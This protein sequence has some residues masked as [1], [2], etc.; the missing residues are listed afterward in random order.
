MI[1]EAVF[2]KMN[3]DLS[4]YLFSQ[5]EESFVH[6]TLSQEMSRFQFVKTG[7]IDGLKRFLKWHDKNA[8]LPTLSDDPVQSERYLFVSLI[9]TCCRVCIE[10]GMPSDESYGLS[11]LYIRRVDKVKT[12]EEVNV[13]AETMLFDYCLRMKE[14]LG[15][16]REYS[17]KI[18]ACIN[19]ISNHLHDRITVKELADELEMNVSWLSVSFAS[20]VGIPVS[21]YI[22]DQKL[23]AAKYLL[24]YNDYSCTD[25]AEYLGFS[26]ASHFSAAFLKYEGVKPTEYRKQNFQKEFSKLLN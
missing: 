2:E 17:P 21:D 20:E 22:R 4:G 24:A 11:D 23:E 14:L 6:A 18:T 25:I 15:R 9:T 19:Y 3:K 8:V 10:A 1:D 5:R 16:K 7:D 13:L 26:S 12:V